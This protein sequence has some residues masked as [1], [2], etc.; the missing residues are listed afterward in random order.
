MVKVHPSRSTKTKLKS[1]HC[2]PGFIECIHVQHLSHS[3][4]PAS[5][6][7]TKYPERPEN[8]LSD[9]TMKYYKMTDLNFVYI[10]KVEYFDSI[11]Y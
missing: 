6:V 11:H 1:V 2:L 9:R 4:S 7:T 5:A 10:G 8:I 3:F